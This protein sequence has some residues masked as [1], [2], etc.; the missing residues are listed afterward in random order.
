MVYRR[1]N[2]WWFKFAWNGETIR[3]STKQA[4][5]RVAEQIEAARRTQMAK[6][7]VGIRDRAPV[8]TL[9]AFADADFLPFVEARFQGKPNTLGYYR[10]GIQ[11]LRN[12]AGLADCKLD[13][14][15]ADKIAGFVATLRERELTVASINRQLE[16]LRRMLK[17]ALEWGKID[18]A[19]PRVE[20]L[21]GENHRDRVL[22][23]DE[24]TRYL[25]AAAAVGNEIEA[26]YRRAL[27][28]IRATL[29]GQEPNK[30]ED[31]FLLRD[32]TALLLDCGPLCQHD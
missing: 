5:K 19:L 14:I 13:T 16:V 10:N 20:M 22:S 24:E 31:P 4:N 2:V 17:L 25:G 12:H 9:A 6:N 28:G 23:P 7:E 27:N 8:P 18:R 1:G 15:T 11:S 26:A 3:E 32:A 30:P 21:P 29:R